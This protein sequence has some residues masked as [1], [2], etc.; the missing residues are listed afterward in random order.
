MLPQK[1]EHGI[2]GSKQGLF[3]NVGPG[4]PTAQTYRTKRLGEAPDADRLAAG[5]VEVHR[6]SG[7]PNMPSN[8]LGSDALTQAKR[9]V[10]VLRRRQL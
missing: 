4:F 7:V 9:R 3:S 6:I 2:V 5:A 8:D 1:V 10:S